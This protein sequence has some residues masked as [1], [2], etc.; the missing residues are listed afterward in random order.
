MLG[1]FQGSSVRTDR[2]LGDIQEIDVVSLFAPIPPIPRP[3]SFHCRVCPPAC[4]GLGL[5]QKPIRSISIKPCRPNSEMTATIWRFLRE[6]R[7][8]ERSNGTLHSPHSSSVT[9]H[10]LVSPNISCCDLDPT[11]P[12]LNARNTLRPMSHL[13]TRNILSRRV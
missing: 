6:R 2:R 12:I 3:L 5:V 7:L 1:G 10:D 13:P 9:D 4:R 8:S 11:F